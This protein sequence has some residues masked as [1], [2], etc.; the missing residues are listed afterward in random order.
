M[1]TIDRVDSGSDT[2]YNSNHY[3]SEYADTSESEK[4]DW[5]NDEEVVNQDWSVEVVGLEAVKGKQDLWV[6]S[7]RLRVLAET[8]SAAMK[9]IGQ[10]G[11]VRT[12]LKTLIIAEGPKFRLL[13]VSQNHG[14]RH[15]GRG[16]T[17]RLTKSSVI[18]WIRLSK[19][20]FGQETLY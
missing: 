8:F 2:G 6:Q 17:D 14:P 12:V 16:L 5:Q 15:G 1:D 19:S 7:S 10:T 3:D 18:G 20:N 4:E 11:P 13:E 9:P